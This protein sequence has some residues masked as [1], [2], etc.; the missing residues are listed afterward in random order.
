MA[1]ETIARRYALAI[2]GLA[3]ERGVVEEV[4]R[5]LGTIL[6]ALDSDD[7]VRRFFYAPVVD[8]KDKTHVLTEAFA[9][10]TNEVALNALLLLVRKR[11]E[12]Y[13]RAIVE[14]YRDL[15]IEASGREP[16]EIV[17]ARELSRPDLDALVER[18]ARIYGKRFVVSEHVDPDLIGGIRITMGDRRIDGTI[19]GRLSDIARALS[20]N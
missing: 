16:L 12:A 13:L 11:R 1:N 8:R 20:E 2:F 9:R 15:A 7:G 4:G 10:G 19:A 17:S 5:D 18:L 14:Q 6:E 3:Q